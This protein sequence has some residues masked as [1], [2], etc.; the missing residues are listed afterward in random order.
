MPWTQPALSRDGRHVVYT[1]WSDLPRR[2]GIIFCHQRPAALY[3]LDIGDTVQA[4]LDRVG[5][6]T[7]AIYLQTSSF[8]RSIHVCRHP[9]TDTTTWP[10]LTECSLPCDVQ[11][12]PA[13]SSPPVPV[14]LTPTDRVARSPVFSR[15]G[16]R[17][18]YLGNQ[19]GFD[20]SPDAFGSAQ[21]SRYLG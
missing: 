2:L 9:F 11:G 19:K 7:I 20:V 5:T 8:R 10:H 21:K 12:A 1:A 14:C 13:P 18:A 15:D 6:L 4:L 16:T 3:A 17:L